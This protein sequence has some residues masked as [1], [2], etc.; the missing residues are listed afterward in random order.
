[1]WSPASDTA[2]TP[3]SSQAL[4][5]CPHNKVFLGGYV[6]SSGSC[7]DTDASSSKVRESGG[8]IAPCGNR[9]MSRAAH[10]CA[11]CSSE[12]PAISDNGVSGRTP[13]SRFEK[14][15]A[16]KNNENT[17]FA[18]CRCRRMERPDAAD[19]QGPV[20]FGE[21]LFSTPVVLWLLSPFLY[22][23]EV[24]KLR[25]LSR[26]INCRW[27]SP[28][29]IRCMMSNSVAMVFP[30]QWERLPQV[31]PCPQETH[32]S[33]EKELRSYSTSSREKPQQQLPQEE[34]RVQ[35]RKGI[36]EGAQQQIR[37]PDV[38]DGQQHQQQQRRLHQRE[39]QGMQK[40]QQQVTEGQ[41]NRQQVGQPKQQHTWRCAID[42][43]DRSQE[44]HAE[45][46]Q[47]LR[48]YGTEAQRRYEHLLADSPLPALSASVSSDSPEAV[49]D[50][51]A[52]VA[53]GGC[54]VPDPSA[55]GAADVTALL[56]DSTRSSGGSPFFYTPPEEVERSLA[57][58]FSVETATPTGGSASFAV[59][60][61]R[62]R[63]KGGE[64][65][66]LSTANR[67]A[68]DG[69]VRVGWS[70]GR[71]KPLHRFNFLR[72]VLL[73]HPAAY[74]CAPLQLRQLTLHLPESSDAVLSL[75]QF[76]TF[77]TLLE[78]CS[79]TLEELH[80]Y[81]FCSFYA[82]V[83]V[84]PAPKG[85]AV[86]GHSSA[87]AVVEEPSTS[88]TARRDLRR[89]LKA[90][91]LAYMSV[92]DPSGGIN[93]LVTAQDVEGDSA[94]DAAAGRPSETAAAGDTGSVARQQLD[95]SPVTQTWKLTLSFKMWMH[96]RGAMEEDPVDEDERRAWAVMDQSEGGDNETS[97]SIGDA[98]NTGSCF[99]T[100]NTYAAPVASTVSVSRPAADSNAVYEPP[101]LSGDLA[102]TVESAAN[103]LGCST[104]TGTVSASSLHLTEP[105]GGT[106]KFNAAVPLASEASSAAVG[107]LDERPINAADFSA[108]AAA[109][110]EDMTFPRQRDVTGGDRP[111][112]NDALQEVPRTSSSRPGNV[113]ASTSSVSDCASFGSMRE[114]AS[115]TAGDRC[116]AAAKSKEKFYKED[117]SSSRGVQSE[118][119]RIPTGPDVF[120]FL[121]ETVSSLQMRCCFPQLRYLHIYGSSEWKTARPY[122]SCLA[123]L[124]LPRDLDIQMHDEGESR[125]NGNEDSGA[126]N[127]GRRG[128]SRSSQ[129]SNRE[130]DYSRNSSVTH[131]SRRSSSA[132]GLDRGTHRHACSRRS[133]S[134]QSRNSNSSS[135]SGNCGSRCQS[136]STPERSSSEQSR[137]A[138]Q[139]DSLRDNQR[140]SRVFKKEHAGTSLNEVM[141]GGIPDDSAASDDAKSRS[142]GAA[143]IEEGEEKKAKARHED[144]AFPAL[145]ELYWQDASCVGED[146]LDFLLASKSRRLRKLSFS[147]YDPST[148]ARLLKECVA[149]PRFF[150]G[151]RQLDIDGL[152]FIWTE[153]EWWWFSGNSWFRFV[154]I[155]RLYAMGRNLL[156]P[157]Y[158]VPHTLQQ[159]QAR[160]RQRQ[161]QRCLQRSCS[162]YKAR[163]TV[164][165][166]EQLRQPDDQ[167]HHRRPRNAARK[168][169]EAARWKEKESDITEISAT[170]FHGAETETEKD[171]VTRGR[172][173]LWSAGS[174]DDESR[175]HTSEE[176]Y[177][178]GQ[179]YT[180]GR[181]NAY[182]ELV[183][184]GECAL[185][186]CEGEPILAQQ[187][188]RSGW[189]RTRLGGCRGALSSELSSHSRRREAT[190]RE[191]R[192]SCPRT[193]DWAC[194]SDE[195]EE[196]HSDE[197]QALPAG[198]HGTTSEV[199]VEGIQR[200]LHRLPRVRK[201]R[202]LNFVGDTLREPRDSTH[203]LG[204]FFPEADVEV[205]GSVFVGRRVLQR[206]LMKALYRDTHAVECRKKQWCRSVGG[207]T[208][209]DTSRRGRLAR[210]IHIARSGGVKDIR[211]RR[212]ERQRRAS[213]RSHCSSEVDEQEYSSDDSACGRLMEF[214]A[215]PF[216]TSTSRKISISRSASVVLDTPATR[217]R[218]AGSRDW[219]RFIRGAVSLSPVGE[220]YVRRWLRQGLVYKVFM[221]L[222]VDWSDRAD[223][224]ADAFHRECVAV[225]VSKVLESLPY[226]MRQKTVKTR[227]YRS[228][229]ILE[230]SDCFHKR[231]KPPQG[232]IN[233][234][235]YF[236]PF[237]RAKEVLEY[238]TPFLLGLDCFFEEVFL[239]SNAVDDDD[240]A[241]DVDDD[242]DGDDD[243][244]AG[245]SVSVGARNESSHEEVQAS[246]SLVDEDEWESRG[247]GND[248]VADAEAPQGLDEQSGRRRSRAAEEH[249]R[250]LARSRTVHLDHDLATNAHTTGTNIQVSGAA[251]QR[252]SL[253]EKQ[254]DVHD[255]A[256]GGACRGRADRDTR[257]E[258]RARDR[259]SVSS[260]LRSAAHTT[261][262]KTGI[263]E[264]EAREG[265][266]ETGR[267][268]FREE[269]DERVIDCEGERS[270][271]GETTVG[272]R[273]T[274]GGGAIASASAGSNQDGHKHT[275]TTDVAELHGDLPNSPRQIL[276]LEGVAGL[277][278][279]MYRRFSDFRKQSDLVMKVARAYKA[280]TRVLLVTDSTL[281]FYRRCKEFYDNALAALARDF[282]AVTEECKESLQVV[283]YRVYRPYAWRCE[284]GDSQDQ[285][286]MPAFIRIFLRKNPEFLLARRLDAV[287]PVDN[288]LESG[289]EKVKTTLTAYVWI[290][291]CRTS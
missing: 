28:W 22:L 273:T 271:N 26:K 250:L 254:H 124:L 139:M 90:V 102:T 33:D 216:W 229:R 153:D 195:E 159:L 219:R 193:N 187:G 34:G 77:K 283:D 133:K 101:A 3:E 120:H 264:E 157:T 129:R 246:D 51:P 64:A 21:L 36:L 176:T 197:A 143:A 11:F 196:S 142:A 17:T 268:M 188:V 185:K 258:C 121:R 40:E 43:R 144:L 39:V 167:Q 110:A 103:C 220:Q 82:V 222:A 48:P 123:C 70:A 16:E 291:K 86:A 199:D 111:I 277:A 265:T 107:A 242:D 46:Q 255:W 211:Q 23:N 247:N 14:E 141:S 146:M 252:Q 147:T 1:M 54:E 87:A 226:W 47:S 66:E 132:H 114:S 9:K 272:F 244:D 166:A 235:G 180:A 213:V 37:E 201:L 109:A 287:R 18:K 45:Q 181:T 224:R 282:K 208:D 190:K 156:A 78:V 55:G 274:E 83:D 145:E 248:H 249:P 173:T 204:S 115:N 8:R 137:S 41:E 88:K 223:L 191:R 236:A 206:L 154:E 24:T 221:K 194:S 148:I 200:A 170:A 12:P 183:G 161:E 57:A 4:L 155:W 72:S 263:V 233:E 179:H 125:R 150:R 95:V 76:R 10:M 68:E 192:R 75:Q 63:F 260:A 178:G 279:P 30:A 105:Q 79:P 52:D 32:F 140:H 67:K 27:L 275:V 116:A 241:D 127:Q 261:I 285:N 98:D 164:L 119:S 74:G 215:S 158:P 160:R 73:R 202:L 138:C 2:F 225:Y 112:E 42:V 56:G 38:E 93:A 94:G 152:N 99:W 286:C 53:V 259:E 288:E 85:V 232:Y 149:H 280:Q 256:A 253:I 267:G 203:V 281:L 278:M 168:G 135:Q 131:S 243:D 257:P 13:F 162:A 113:H 69:K 89:A 31:H 182:A 217:S 198:F 214:P 5:S 97:S 92:F 184:D 234:R 84:S 104:G 205:Q 171:E 240:D 108:A 134:Q 58:S 245:S 100:V 175:N 163:Y 276:R 266:E 106:S 81:D 251:T 6:A 284:L 7:T 177:E 117:H 122:Y 262:A 290:K 126:N 118:F 128:S 210:D 172:G 29:V 49:C 130:S 227:Q 209:R 71:C 270:L 44:R 62:R 96:C 80:L 151:L 59:R 239:P 61:A 65:A 212:A 269:K 50:V 186:W 218:G 238:F 207:A 25:L 230:L 15:K 20:T 231:D 169:K 136:R 60:D 228:L 289:L 91:E 189:E 165:K 237:G 35:Q 174:C 19:H